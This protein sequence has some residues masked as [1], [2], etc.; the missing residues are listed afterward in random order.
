ML[1]RKDLKKKLAYAFNI[2]DYNKRGA[3]ETDLVR[4]IIYGIL[5]L[6]HPLSEDKSIADLYSDAFNQLKITE[7]IKRGMF[8]V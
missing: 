2:Y 7:V 3:L 5:D 6:F 4:E 8:V 1:C